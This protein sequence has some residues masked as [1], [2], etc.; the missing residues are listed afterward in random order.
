VCVNGVYRRVSSDFGARVYSKDV[1]STGQTIEIFRAKT[2]SNSTY[3]Y[4]SMIRKGMKR[5]LG[6]D[7]CFYWAP[8]EKMNCPAPPVGTGRWKTIAFGEAPLP[9]L[10]YQYLQEDCSSEDESM[11][12]DSGED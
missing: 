12:S 1:E 9:Q 5:G 10:Q 4:I 2:M 11:D 6:S 3:W 8:V 7:I